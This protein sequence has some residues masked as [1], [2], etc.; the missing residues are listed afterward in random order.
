MIEKKNDN[1]ASRNRDISPYT[2]RVIICKVPVS[3][4]SVEFFK[5]EQCNTNTYN[6]ECVSKWGY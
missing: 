1:D 2:D 6:Y 3:G 5:D 4:I